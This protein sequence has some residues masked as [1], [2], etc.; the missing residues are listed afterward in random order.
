MLPLMTEQPTRSSADGRTGLAREMGLLGLVATGICSMIGAAIN[1]IPF[2]IQRTVPGIGPCVLP[3]YLLATVPAIL[4]GLAYAIL[5]SAMPRAG[6]SYVYASRAL[7]PYLGFVASFSQWFGLSIAIGVVSYVLIPFLRDIAGALGWQS[8]ATTL[9]TGPVRLAVAFV[10]L[11]TFVGVNLRG[12]KWYERTLV[13][14]M[15]LMFVLG[16]VVI[17]AGFLVRPRG[18]RGGAARAGRQAACRAVG[19]QVRIRAHSS[20]P[21]RCCSPAS[22]ASTRSRRR[23]ARRGTRAGRCRWRSGLP[24]SSWGVLHSLHGGRLPRGAVAVRGRRVA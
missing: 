15:F 24:C 13:P 8:L 16:A 22:S 10:F 14:L 11:W 5:A 2:T 6:G 4:A 20:Q 23:A 17:V 18:L 9:E 7:S 19:R 21:P 3:A 1:V 12:V